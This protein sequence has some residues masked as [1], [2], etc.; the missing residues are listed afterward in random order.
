MASFSVL[1]PPGTEPGSFAAADRSAFVKDG[2]CWPALFVPPIWLL[3]RRMWLVFL[4]WLVVVVAIGA[5]SAIS[6]LPDGASSLV[7][8]AFFCWF[9]LEA[10]A[11]RRWTLLSRGWRFAG[12]ATGAD[13]SDAEYRF[14][15]RRPP[16]TVAFYGP[17][18]GHGAA[19]LASSD[20]VIGMFPERW[21]G[22]P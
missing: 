12:L 9:A 16:S 1:E 3:W 2:W 21:D 6:D 11:L 19:Q 5:L 15:E 22:R 7:T 17:A 4:F 14:F 8:L 20:A 18:R 10:N 13:R